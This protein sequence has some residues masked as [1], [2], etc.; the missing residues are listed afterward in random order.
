MTHASHVC[1]CLE[2][3]ISRQPLFIFVESY[4]FMKDLVTTF[5]TDLIKFIQDLLHLKMCFFFSL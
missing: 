2:L 4:F 5:N 1:P 3:S